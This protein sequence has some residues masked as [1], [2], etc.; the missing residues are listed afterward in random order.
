MDD[1]GKDVLFGKR[2]F[3]GFSRRDV[4]RYIDTLQKQNLR[5]VQGGEDALRQARAQVQALT[6]QLRDAQARID[7]L[8]TQ[9]R[10]QEA[11]RP[12]EESAQQPSAQAP[13][14]PPEPPVR[15]TQSAPAA[16][17]APGQGGTQSSL[18]VETTA[19]KTKKR[20]FF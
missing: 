8:E 2:M 3:G 19:G 6:A 18:F 13:S 12:A 14:T 5:T 9:L 15:R 7:S 4:M 11:Q 20:R 10:E 1:I 17:P 16:Q